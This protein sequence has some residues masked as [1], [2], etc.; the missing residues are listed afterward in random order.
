MPCPYFEPQR[1]VI[2]PEHRNAR[3]PLIE[4]YEGC[5][6]AREALVAA[7]PELRLECCNQGYSRGRCGYFPAREVRSCLRYNVVR[8]TASTL[9]ILC[10]EE[11]NYAPLRWHA[12]QYIFEKQQLAPEL[13]DA[14]T[15]AQILAFCR[16]YLARF[17]G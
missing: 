9:D 15:R 7:P 11:Q 1:V 16:S 14:C 13:Q 4:E 8:R 6:H 10:I 17:P 12:V 5:C 3:L 2:H